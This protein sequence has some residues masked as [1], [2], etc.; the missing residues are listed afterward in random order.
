[1]SSWFQP[2]LLILAECTIGILVGLSLLIH[3]SISNGPD[4]LLQYFDSEQ[5][6]RRYRNLWLHPKVISKPTGKH[7]LPEQIIPEEHYIWPKVMY[8]SFQII[9]SCLKHTAIW[10][11]VFWHSFNNFEPSIQER[12]SSDEFDSPHDD[13][14]SF[15]IGPGVVFVPRPQVEICHFSIE[16]S[17]PANTTRSIQ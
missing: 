10:Q 16:K 7:L 5:D 14:S 8:I 4:I 3:P 15:P 1:M 12:W 9:L 2:R 17:N 13:G 11:R 6:F